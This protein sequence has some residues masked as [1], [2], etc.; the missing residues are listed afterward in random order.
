MHIGIKSLSYQLGSVRKSL[1]ELHNDGKLISPVET[2]KTFGFENIYETKEENSY[3]LALSAVSQLLK[4]SSLDPLAIDVILYAGA[5][6]P[7]SDSIDHTLQL[8]NYPSSKLQ[9]ESGISHASSMSI[10]QQGCSA[11][12]SA[13]N[14]AKS[15][16]YA[17][18]N[19]HNVLCVS[20]DVLPKQ[21][22]R[23]VI[24][25][26][27]SDGAAAVLVSDADFQFEILASNHITKGYYWNTEKMQNEIIASYF[28]TAKNI[29]NKILSDSNLSS[30][31]IAL[32][33][34]HNVSLRSWKILLGL[35]NFPE[36][37][38]FG[39]NISRIGHC[40]G[41]DTVI[42]LKNALEQKRIKSGDIVL[43][44]NFGFGSHWSS[45]L[46]KVQKK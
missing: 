40:I 31:E 15:L 26:V 29:I 18:K 46:L 24:Y 42:N 25:N 41:S 45:M 6:T 17:D 22:S 32:L 8:F 21:L 36:E 20:T 10:G 39:E 2:L 35:I 3:D 28:P 9:Y 4:D 44:F 16:I 11:M 5:T 12:F 14:I 13:I 34:P 43:L 30:K 1:H 19:V 27:L 38:F 7:L 23:E 37:K 33:V